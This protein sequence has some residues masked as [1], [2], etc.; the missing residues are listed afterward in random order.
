MKTTLITGTSRGLGYGLCKFLLSKNHKV[1]S[2]SRSN[3]DFSH[4]N[5]TH[6]Q[7][8]ITNPSVSSIIY[9]HIKNKKI[10]NCI[11]NAGIADNSLFHKMTYL[12]KK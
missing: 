7:N 10:D 4:E 9:E 8:D 11:I 2:I 1:I 6:L 12:A 5:L 3:I